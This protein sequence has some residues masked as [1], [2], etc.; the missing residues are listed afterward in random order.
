MRRDDDPSVFVDSGRGSGLRPTIDD[1]GDITI[2]K[3]KPINVVIDD[4]MSLIPRKNLN[5]Y[6]GVTPFQ[7]D[8]I[9]DT[10]DQADDPFLKGAMAELSQNN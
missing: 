5:D 10:Q 1:I 7:R 8:V 9:E 4:D 3:R 6:D 2:P